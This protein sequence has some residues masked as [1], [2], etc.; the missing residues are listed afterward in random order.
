MGRNFGETL[1]KFHKL[2]A[3]FRLSHFA[4]QENLHTMKLSHLLISFFASNIISIEKKKSTDSFVSDDP[5]V[6]EPAC[7]EMLVATEY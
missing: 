7:Y 2:L 1:Q 6:Y 5:R 3:K 4:K